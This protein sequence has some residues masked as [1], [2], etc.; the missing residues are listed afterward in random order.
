MLELAD[1]DAIAGHAVLRG[2]AGELEGLQVDAEYAGPRYFVPSPTPPEQ[3]DVLSLGQMAN[4]LAVRAPAAPA[5]AD[6][7]PADADADAPAVPA[8][9]SYADA[10]AEANVLVLVFRLERDAEAPSILLPTRPISTLARSVTFAS[11]DPMEL[12]CRYG[13]TFW[14]E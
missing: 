10:S 4:D 5:A 1:V 8:S 2:A 14:E 11:T 12:G 9:S 6:D 13:E 3:L 7:A